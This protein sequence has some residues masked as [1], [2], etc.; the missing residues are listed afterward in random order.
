MEHAGIDHATMSDNENCPANVGGRNTIECPRDP[1]GEV[2]PC[3]APRGEWYGGIPTLDGAVEREVLIPPHAFG[4]SGT[5]FFDVSIVGIDPAVEGGGN[6]GSGLSGAANCRRH[7]DIGREPFDPQAISQRAG[8]A[9]SEIGQ[10]SAMSDALDRS[11]DVA[12]CLPVANN[13]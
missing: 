3:L 4:F 5:H 11:L 9:P 7:D 10:P 13:K 1:G 12:H 6:R 2:H 8:L